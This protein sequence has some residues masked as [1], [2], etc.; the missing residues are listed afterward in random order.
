MVE[1]A[2]KNELITAHYILNQMLVYLGLV[3]KKDKDIRIQSLLYGNLAA[4]F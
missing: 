1:V 2:L 4:K 3:Y